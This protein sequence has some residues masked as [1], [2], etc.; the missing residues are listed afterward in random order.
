VIRALEL[1]HSLLFNRKPRDGATA[2]ISK[3]TGLRA[4]LKM[5]G[6]T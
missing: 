4:A 2:G 5:L 6:T 1:P 3:A